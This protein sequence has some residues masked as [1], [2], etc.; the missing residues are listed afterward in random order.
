MWK[1]IAGASIENFF[2]CVLPSIYKPSGEFI[3]GDNI[4]S[5]HIWVVSFSDYE[6]RLAIER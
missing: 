2:V 3:A 4:I 1:K 5:H 6:Q